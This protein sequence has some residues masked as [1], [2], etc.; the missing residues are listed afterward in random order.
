MRALVAVGFVGALGLGSAGCESILGIE[1][2]QLAPQADAGGQDGVQSDS[3][4]PA[5]ALDSGMMADTAAPTPDGPTV[6]LDSATAADSGSMPDSAPNDGGVE[7]DSP[8]AIVTCSTGELRC[9][10]N[11]PQA[12]DGG[13]WGNLTA[14][15]GSTPVCSNGVCGSYLCTGGVRTTAASIG[16]DGG[17]RLVSG[18]FE[19]GTRTCGE[20]GV[21]VAGGIVP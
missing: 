7:A 13:A 14:C 20:A 10:G 11:A 18:G 6:P 3:S 21:C 15:G 17:V 19:L 4:T 16:P 5:D 2:H 1:D 9:S 12:C 8:S